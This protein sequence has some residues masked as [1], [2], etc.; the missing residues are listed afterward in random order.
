MEFTITAANPL[1]HAD[2]IKRLFATHGRPEFPAFFDRAYGAAVRAGGTSWLA[3]DGAGNLVMHVACFPRRFRFGARDIV[4]GLLMNA[5]AAE[6]YRS[7]FPARTLMRRARDDSAA[8]GIDFL[9][10]DPNDPAR[11]V[12]EGSGFHRI[13]TLARH[14]L[15]VGD[16]RWL[17]DGAIRLLHAARARRMSNSGGRPAAAAAAQQS[18]AAFDAPWGDSPRLR[19]YYDAGVY[20]ARLEEYPGPAD[21]WFTFPTNGAT[22]PLAAGLLIRGPDASGVA[23]LLAIRRRPEIPLQVVIP[24]LVRALRERGCTRLQLLTLA[25]SRFSTELRSVGFVIRR[26]ATPVLAAAL[27]AAGDAALDAVSDWEITGLDCDR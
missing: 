18:P 26:D 7:F 24:G 21:R 23:T 9:Y 22:S 16:R 27:T 6:A 20:W 12:L 11:A 17:V 4:G 10:T 13:G 25:E 19:P 2:E 3:R 5:M 14:V 8:G 1:D 15:L